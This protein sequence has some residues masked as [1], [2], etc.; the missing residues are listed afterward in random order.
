MTGDTITL[1]VPHQ[2]HHAKRPHRLHHARGGWRI[3]QVAQSR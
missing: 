2:P 3:G 1:V